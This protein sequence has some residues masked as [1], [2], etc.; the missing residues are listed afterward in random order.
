MSG[1]AAL[2]VL[3]AVV[4]TLLWLPYTLPW[5]VRNSGLLAR[6]FHLHRPSSMALAP[7]GS[8]GL[9]QRVPTCL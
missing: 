3:E 8:S 5:L 9:T 1:L 4:P 7:A 6:P 2:A